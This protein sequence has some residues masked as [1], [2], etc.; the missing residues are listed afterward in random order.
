MTTDNLHDFEEK[1]GGGLNH[2]PA[3]KKQ[4][5]EYITDIYTPRLVEEIKEKIEELYRGQR[6]IGADMSEFQPRV[7]DMDFG[8][9]DAIANVL[10]ALSPNKENR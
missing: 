8:W 1:I 9:N 4:V 5:L 3:Y 10:S 2:N 7:D 6:K